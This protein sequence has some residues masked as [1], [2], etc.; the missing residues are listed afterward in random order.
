MKYDERVCKFNIVIL[1]NPLEYTFRGR[2]K[3]PENLTDLVRPSGLFQY[4]LCS[5]RA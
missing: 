1:C 4:F 2:K 5:I 3:S